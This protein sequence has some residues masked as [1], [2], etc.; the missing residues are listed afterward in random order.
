[1]K[2]CIWNL[3]SIIINAQL[4]NKLTI[5]YQKKKNCEVLLNLLWDEGYILGYK[6]LSSNSNIIIIYLKY[7][8][9]YPV[10]VNFKIISKPSLKI[11][12]SS[13][14]L[15]KIK[16]NQGL[17]IMSTTKGLKSLDFCKKFNIGGEPFLIIK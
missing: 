10:I 11:Y 9:N 13:R 8:N 7:I 4:V 5:K 12:Y 17:L 14:Q 16:P 3:I 15:W 2:N 6:N 1:M